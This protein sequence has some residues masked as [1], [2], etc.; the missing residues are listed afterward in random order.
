MRRRTP[1]TLDA[2]E[3]FQ[4]S[5]TIRRRENTLED[6]GVARARERRWAAASDAFEDPCYT[7]VES[8]ADVEQAARGNAIDAFLVLPC[9]APGMQIRTWTIECG[10]ERFGGKRRQGRVGALAA[11][12][13]GPLDTYPQFV[14][15]RL[16][17]PTTW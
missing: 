4:Q 16:E 6:F 11:A 8:L 14:A 17:V 12:R 15:H 2:G 7:H 3:Q 1:R 10:L 9:R 5:R 13:E